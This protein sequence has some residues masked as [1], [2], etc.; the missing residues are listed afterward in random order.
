[1]LRGC[2]GDAPGML[3]RF[4]GRFKRCASWRQHILWVYPC[5]PGSGDEIIPRRD[6]H[7][8]LRGSPRFRGMGIGCADAR[9]RIVFLL[10]IIII[11]LPVREVREAR[12]A[13]AHCAGCDR[14]NAIM[15]DAI[16]R[17][18]N[19]VRLPA[20]ARMH[21]AVIPSTGAT[22]TLAAS[23]PAQAPNNSTP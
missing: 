3:R 18:I 14:L 13:A 9:K 20:A 4:S 22:T 11:G 2:A 5:V 8:Q 16:T 19:A 1:M 6:R 21:T 12:F 17:A 23:A 15:P 7:H 10:N